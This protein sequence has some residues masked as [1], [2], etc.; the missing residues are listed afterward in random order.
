MKS[1]VEWMQAVRLPVMPEV[2]AKL[3]SSYQDEHV[4]ITYLRDVIAKDPVLTAALLRLA[5]SPLHG[6]S[7]TVNSLDAAIS[8]LGISKVRTQ[9]IAVCMSDSF[10]LPQGMSRQDFW[11]KSMQCAGYAMWLALA[12]GLDESE[13]WLTGMLLHLGE[14]LISQQMT[15]ERAAVA[16]PANPTLS[17]WQM[18]QAEAGIDEGQVMAAAATQWY[19]PPSIVQALQHCANP[20]EADTFYAPAAVV[21]LAAMLA[22]LDAVDEASLASLPAEVVTRLGIEVAWLAQH[23]PDPRTFTDTSIL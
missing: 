22:D 21:H 16:Q 20:L 1:L 15:V 11:N 18:Q 23:I 4:E 3:V 9:A 14:I 13:A 10:D 12:V 6:L 17:R 2:A 7:R 5:N 8:L 19:F